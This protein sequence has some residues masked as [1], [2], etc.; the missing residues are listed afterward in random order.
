MH[1]KKLYLLPLNASN[2]Q[3]HLLSKPSP[4]VLLNITLFCRGDNAAI[5]AIYKQ[6]TLKLYV[7][8]YGYLKSQEEAEDVVADCFEKLLLMRF[9]KRQQKFIEERIDLKAF[10][11]VVVK[12]KSLDVLKTK[13]NRN[14][15]L[16]KVK[17]FMPVL[18]HN[19]S[20][21]SFTTGY[22]NKNRTIS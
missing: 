15:I 17:Y 21:Q 5:G 2:Y 14:Q 10:L 16:D 7:I 11:I 6:W 3:Y 4:I 8:A 13:N 1:R 12:N 18:A 9:E 19:A 22:T 20:K